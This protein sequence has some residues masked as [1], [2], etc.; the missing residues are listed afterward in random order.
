MP[1]MSVCHRHRRLIPAGEK[2]AAC[3][4]ADNARR[5]KKSA[6][7]GLT[8]THWQQLRRAR[9]KQAKGVCELRLR[10]CTRRA[11]TVHLDPRLGGNHRAA[12]LGDVRAACLRCHG[13]LDGA[14]S[15]QHARTA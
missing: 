6:A 2:C 4:T 14:R 3:A 10:G 8:T 13:V 11:S 7:H 15:H 1:T 9:L 5:A 12:T